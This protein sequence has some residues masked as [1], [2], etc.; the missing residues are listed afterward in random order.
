MVHNTTETSSEDFSVTYTFGF[1]DSPVEQDVRIAFSPES[2]DDVELTRSLNESKRELK[3]TQD[4]YNKL[5]SSEGV[6]HTWDFDAVKQL[7]EKEQANSKQ[8]QEQVNCL[9]EELKQ[10]MNNMHTI[11]TLK[12]LKEPANKVV[13]LGNDS[14]CAAESRQCDLAT[15]I[16]TVTI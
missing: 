12:C 9:V 4:R 16:M 8:L 7:L 15:K 10:L 6:V 2:S 5:R 13:E 11:S 1:E 3:K 14:Q